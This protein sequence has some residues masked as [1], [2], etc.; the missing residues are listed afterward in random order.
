MIPPRHVLA[1][2]ALALVA[3]AVTAYVETQLSGYARTVVGFAGI[4]AILVVSLS[5]SNGLTGLFSL[6][7]P[8]FMMVGG[9]VAAV[10]TFPVSRKGFML[11]ALPEWLAGAELPLFPATVAGGLAA[12]LVA[13]VVGFPVL[14]LR[15]HYLA[16]ATLGLII[17]MRVAVNNADGL[18]RGA[19]GLNGIPRLTTLWVILGWLAATLVVCWRLK[20]SSVGRSL[21]AIREN[22]MAAACMGVRRASS[23]LIAFSVGAFFAG[24]GGALWAHLLTNLTPGSFDLVL[25]FMLVVMVVVGGSGSLGGAVVAAIGITVLREV[26]RPVEQAVG[27]YGLVQIIIAVLLIATLLLRPQ[28]FFGSAEPAFL[29]RD[30]RDRKTKPGRKNRPPEGPGRFPE[31]TAKQ[32]ARHEKA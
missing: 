10:L 25:A 9:Y 20:H 2:A 29:R 27:A 18:T 24:V 5:F 14:R 1:W 32:E 13:V 7:H 16:V 4:S 17:I 8:A 31:H 6:G 26:L 28:G 3:L 19:L 11:P 22:E 30:T 15:G 23:K 21:M 12:A